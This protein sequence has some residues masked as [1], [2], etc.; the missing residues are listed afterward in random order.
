MGLK[1]TQD[2]GAGRWN[3]DGKVQGLSGQTLDRLKALQATQGSLSANDLKVA[4]E[5]DGQID[6]AERELLEEMLAGSCEIEV[7]Q[8]SSQAEFSPSLLRFTAPSDE[9]TQTLEG[10]RQQD[11]TENRAISQSELKQLLKDVKFDDIGPAVEPPEADPEAVPEATP[12]LV[13][14]NG[15]DPGKP[16]NNPNAGGEIQP[17]DIN[18]AQSL[19]EK[20]PELKLDLPPSILNDSANQ[21]FPDAIDSLAYQHFV[22]AQQ[23]LHAE[24]G[25]AALTPDDRNQ[26]LREQLIDRFLTPEFAALPTQQQQALRDL[27]GEFTPAEL[28]AAEAQGTGGANVEKTSAVVGSGLGGHY[29]NSLLGSIKGLSQSGRLTPDVLQALTAMQTAPLHPEL[30]DQR[31]SLMRSA[32]HEIAFPNEINQHSKGTCAATSSGQMLLAIRDPARYVQ[33][34]SSLASPDGAVPPSL[35]PGAG[36]QSMQREPDTL[37]DDA[38][39]RSLSSRLV[40]PAMM[41]YANGTSISY[42]N[43]QG[44]GTH[45]NGDHGLYSHQSNHLLEAIFGQ[46]SY[47]E[48]TTWMPFDP[49]SAELLERIESTLAQGEPVPIGMDWGEEA[50]AVLV[51]K[52]DQETER[53]YFMNPWGELQWMPLDEFSERLNSASLAQNPRGTGPAM[54]NLPGAAANPEAYYQI[55]RERY[56]TLPEYLAN[57]PT[58]R[59]RLSDDQRD[60]L[61]D[62][63]ERLEYPVEMM[64]LFKESAESFGLPQSLLDQINGVESQDQLHRL[65]RLTYVLGKPGVPADVRAQVLAVGPEKNLNTAQFQALFSAL[66]DGQYDQLPALLAPARQAALQAATGMDDVSSLSQDQLLTRFRQLDRG[67]TSEADYQKLE[68]IAGAAT[69]ATKAQMLRELMNG[70][71]TDRAEQAMNM[72]LTRTPAAEQQQILTVLDLR[73]LGNETENADRAAETLHT[74]LKAGFDPSVMQSHLESFFAGVESQTWFFNLV[75][76]DDDTAMSF[77]RQF[78]DQT[79]S[80]VPDSVKLRFFKALDGGTTHENEYQAMERLARVAGPAG[81]ADMIRYLVAENPNQRQED[82]IFRTLTATPPQG[83]PATTRDLVSRLDAR[84]LANALEND[85]Q[86]A[87]VAVRLAETG[88]SHKSSDFLR[89]LAWDHRDE[90]LTRFVRDPKVQANDRALYRALPVATLRDMTEYLMNGDTNEDEEDCI[91]EL[92]KASGWDQYGALMRDAGLRERLGDELDRQD[93][94]QLD[95]WT[96]EYNR[97]QAQRP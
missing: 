66:Y 31:S 26:R 55:S 81:Q 38:S 77:L 70:A 84:D 72:I 36:R 57:E 83:Q 13:P 39:G 64:N 12:E 35:L 42:D 69:P 79:L 28:I 19:P 7:E 44:I 61:Q 59:D 96:A 8:L 51:T 41:E 32:L 47:D 90:A 25:A 15:L 87:A 17:V 46:G 78:D 16:V 58:F 50:H 62:T 76:T 27:L 4:V 74:I 48:V 93:I 29:V 88:P 60:Q 89:T 10:L 2:G 1:L 71:T 30:A 86:A 40:Q 9:D 21:H 91:M 14:G 53:A 97:R 73:R 95:R 65:N 94:A 24:P 18:S 34:V 75:N 82:I 22:Q 54:A 49:N 3:L 52:I 56:C 80:Q 68:V 67:W 45:T 6:P 5:L 43:S 11:E 33:L 20:Q 37:A 85:R 92:L 23:A 63:L